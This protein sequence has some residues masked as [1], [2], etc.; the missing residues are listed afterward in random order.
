MVISVEQ[1]G[2][3]KKSKS[4]DLYQYGNENW[5]R[6]KLSLKFAGAMFGS[7]H[8]IAVDYQYCSTPIRGQLCQIWLSQIAK[9][10]ERHYF[11]TCFSLD[12]ILL[13]FF[14]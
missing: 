4:I 12:E 5:G 3:K 11:I 14:F 6:Y 8:R 10:V 9:Q 7:P 2:N 13:N 1:M